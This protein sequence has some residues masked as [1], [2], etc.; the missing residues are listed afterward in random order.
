[1]LGSRKNARTHSE[2]LVDELTQ[3]YDHLK[4][5]VAHL[6]GGA[7]ERVTPSYD[8]TRNVASRGWGNTKQAFTP[9]YEQMRDGAMNARQTY[10]ITEK[11]KKGRWPML[12]GLLAIGAAVGAAGAVAARRR[13]AAEAEWDEYE[14]LGGIDQNY[15][16]SEAKPSATKR[17]TDGAASV[18]GS[19]SSS[20]GKLADSLHNRSARTSGESMSDTD[21]DPGSRDGR[22]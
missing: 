10:V 7:A 6:A 15:G 17:L 19:V 18:A 1:V 3:S 5:A 20:A 22:L 2:Q 14:P 4:M 8:R 12:A 11:E 9:I 13:R 16:M 21:D